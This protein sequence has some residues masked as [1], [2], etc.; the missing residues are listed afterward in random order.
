MVFSSLLLALLQVL[1]AV[2]HW[3]T[4]RVEVRNSIRRYYIHQ[5]YMHW[6]HLFAIALFGIYNYIW[7][8]LCYNYLL[9]HVHFIDFN[10]VLLHD[11]DL[12]TFYIAWPKIEN[13]R[14]RYRSFSLNIFYQKYI[15]FECKYYFI[16]NKTLKQPYYIG[17]NKKIH[18]GSSSH[19]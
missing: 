4:S 7:S 17:P 12:F 13:P 11:V 9:L 2:F 8:P 18:F 19:L 10:L 16:W 14:G 3:T 5:N 1:Q 15:I 6:I